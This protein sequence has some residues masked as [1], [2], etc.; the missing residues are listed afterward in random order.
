[1]YNKA[2]LTVIALA[3]SVIA[4]REVG[5]PA[6]GQKVIQVEICGQEVNRGVGTSVS[7]AE[8]LTDHD[9]VRRLIVTK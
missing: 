7:C 4:I 9:G 5:V 3:L 2:M 1:M 6:F 8:M